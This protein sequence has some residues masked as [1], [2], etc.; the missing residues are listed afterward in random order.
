MLSVI[1]VII[2]IYESVCAK[3]KR[4]R[5]R[6]EQA[7]KAEKLAKQRKIEEKERWWA[8]ADF[9][10]RKRASNASVEDEE[11]VIS[12]E[13]QIAQ[14]YSMDYSRWDSWTPQDPATR[15][16]V[17]VIQYYHNIF[18]PTQYISF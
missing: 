8:G 4:E 12:S 1:F 7:E 2:F 16:E 6:K 13:T 17:I 9:F 18:Y 14:R 10:V 3:I 11:G 15:A 5:L